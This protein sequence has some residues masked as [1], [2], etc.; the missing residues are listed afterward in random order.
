MTKRNFTN[1]DDDLSDIK[2]NQNAAAPA[3]PAPTQ[4][5]AATA[6]APAPTA[7]A[8]TTEPL[9]DLSDD[10]EAPEP[11]APAAKSSTASTAVDNDLVG[12]E[13]EFDDEDTIKF[14]DGLDRI[15]P[16]KKSTKQIRFALL[17]FLKPRVARSH[18]VVTKEGKPNHIC[19]SLKGEPA[20]CCQK[21]DAEGQQHV[22]AL[23]LEY[24]N[25]NPKTA[26]YTKDA[27][28]GKFPAIEYRI[29]YVDL[30]RSNF[31]SLQGLVQEDGSIYNYDLAMYL[32]GNKYEFSVR[33]TAALWKNNPEL[34]KEVEEACQAYVQD[35]GAKLARK[36]GK[37]TTLI[38][39]K[40]LISGMATGG[41]A[42]ANL[43]NVE[44]L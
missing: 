42:E 29:G 26:K 9:E 8:T 19:L 31:R 6:T 10:E 44:E 12:Q 30:S 7:A 15:R 5:A 2:T 3:A 16:E 20:Y 17:P 33:N 34:A 40:A 38:Q 23:A 4:P 1:L 13:I 22:V 18:Y 43:D 11:P 28:T 32:N 36:L 14:G 41:A 27:T 21:L 35:G 25:V 24:T 37:K 39:W